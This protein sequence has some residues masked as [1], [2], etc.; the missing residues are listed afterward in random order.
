MWPNGQQPTGLLCPRDSL[1]KNTGVGCYF[2]LQKI[3]CKHVFKKIVPQLRLTLCDPRDCSHQPYQS[4]EFSR[5][6]YWSGLPF[7]SPLLE[8]C[9]SKLK[10]GI[11]SYWLEWPSAK[12]LQTIYAGEG[13]EKSEPSCSVGRNA[14]WYRHY[15]EQCEDSLKKNGNRTAIWPRNPI[16]GHTP[17][18]NQN[19]KRH[20][21]PARVH[22]STVYNS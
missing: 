13:V 12:S 18:G 10:W 7:F 16:T 15:G 20:T 17:W 6:E 4:M 2:G 11:T 8:K 14:N 21:Y 19:W 5:Q 22:C 1:G 3:I 9:K